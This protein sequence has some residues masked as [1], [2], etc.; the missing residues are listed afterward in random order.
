MQAL[1][2]LQNLILQ[3]D[4]IPFHLREGLRSEI[5]LSRNIG[6]LCDFLTMLQGCSLSDSV[7]DHIG[8]IKREILIAQICVECLS[9]IGEGD[10][11]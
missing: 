7:K 8:E 3:M 5:L 10:N 1:A 4:F 2:K 11:H 6:S 9:G